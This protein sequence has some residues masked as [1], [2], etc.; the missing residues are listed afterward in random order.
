M[1]PAAISPF[2]VLVVVLEGGNPAVGRAGE[3]AFAALQQAGMDVLLDDREQSPGSKL[4]DADLIGI[5]VQLVIGNVWEQHHRFEVVERTSKTRQQVEPS[6][7]VETIKTLLD[8]LSPP[9]S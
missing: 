1:W 8:K 5:P 2:Q 3:E 6:R 9:S 7:L 4:K